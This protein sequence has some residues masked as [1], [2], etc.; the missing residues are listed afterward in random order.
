MLNLAQIYAGWIPVSWKEL[1][2]PHLGLT[3]SSDPRRGFCG[4][5]MI[6]AE[7]PEP[8]RS[9]WETKRSYFLFVPWTI[10]SHPVRDE[11]EEQTALEIQLSLHETKQMGHM[12][13]ET[14]I[15]V[16]AGSESPWY[17]GAV[18]VHNLVTL[19][20]RGKAHVNFVGVLCMSP[21]K[22]GAVCLYL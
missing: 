7:N 9:L 8:P 11:K 22:W 14:H 10:K 4:I 13:F 21:S 15:M 2:F 5:T 12:V 19:V 6:V 3:E 1:T 16:W 18:T 17:H 20:S